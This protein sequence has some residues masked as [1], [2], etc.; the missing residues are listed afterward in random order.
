VNSQVL[1]TGAAGFIGSHVC[2]HLVKQGH[3]VVGLDDL[4][5]GFRDQV[6]DG[7]EFVK[8]SV[9]DVALVQKLHAEHQ[10]EYVFHLAAYAAEGLSHFIKRFNY[11]NNVVGSANLINAAGS[12]A[13]HLYPQQNAAGTAGSNGQ[14]VGTS[15]IKTDNNREDARLDWAP[16]DHFTVFGRGTRAR[17]TASVPTFFN[18]GADQ[19]TG[20]NEP[21]VGFT[22]GAIW[23]PDAKS[24]YNILLGA[25]YWR[26]VQT[27]ASQGYSAAAIGIPATTVALFQATTMPQLSVSNYQGLGNAEDKQSVSGNYHGELN[28]S[29][30][31]L[32][33]SLKFGLAYQIQ[34]WDPTDAYSALFNFNNG[35][36]SGPTASV[37]TSSSGNAIASLLMGVGA[38]GNAPYNPGLEISQKSYALYVQDT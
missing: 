7:V 9:T 30:Q 31:Y 29:R 16:T 12:L 6:P 1:V 8:G 37:D 22:G 32:L 35:L 5:G 13:V 14:F 10:F 33:H 2:R 20:Q 17:Q 18:N 15:N 38:S 11:T 4:S 28:G 3:H 19:T 24:T 23:A 21:R 26:D 34:R 25:S 36:T 27:T